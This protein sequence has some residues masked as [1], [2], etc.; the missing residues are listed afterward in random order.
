MIKI[1]I[2]KI[3]GKMFFALFA[4][5]AAGCGPDREA[6]VREKVAER[7]TAFREKKKAECR[8]ETYQ[9][10][11]RIVDSLLLEEAKMALND[12]LARLRPGKPAK[13]APLPPIDS[14]PVAPLFD[15]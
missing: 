15:H 4:F 9:K 5:M 6:I 13:P 3:S 1:K 12:S 7:V 2:K 8:E 14:A 10:A 11:E